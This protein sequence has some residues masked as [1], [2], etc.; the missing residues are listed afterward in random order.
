MTTPDCCSG[1]H[2]VSPLRTTL[3]LSLRGSE[4]LADRRPGRACLESDIPRGS[5]AAT[6]LTAEA[7]RPVRGY[8]ATSEPVL[9]ADVRPV[10]LR[11]VLEERH[12]PYVGVQYR[13]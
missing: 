1:F 12:G 6:R 13:F 2:P 8:A 4:R 11:A 5:G 3:M 10:T 7:S 9:H